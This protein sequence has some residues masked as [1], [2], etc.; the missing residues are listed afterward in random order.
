[1]DHTDGA[2]WRNLVGHRWHPAAHLPVSPSGETTE[3]KTEPPKIKKGV[4]KER[5]KHEDEKAPA[6]EEITAPEAKVDG[7]K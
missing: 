2:G 4:G 1:M 6:K 7:T 3:D 5:G